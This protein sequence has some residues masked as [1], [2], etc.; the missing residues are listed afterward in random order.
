MARLLHEAGCPDRVIAAA[1]LH[2]T[3]EHKKATTAE[4]TERFGEEVAALVVAVTEDQELRSYSRRKAGLRQQVSAAG[5]EAAVL[6][7]A[8]KVSKVR[9]F[10]EQR[11]HGGGA[12][13]RSRLR[14]L[15]HYRQS[16]EMLEATIPGHPLVAELRRQLGTL[17]GPAAS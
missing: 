14:R 15:L 6:F 1:L 3:V 11:V 2:E 5:N 17:A 7:A 10:R 8:D 16:L 4:L 12:M 9:E 13:A